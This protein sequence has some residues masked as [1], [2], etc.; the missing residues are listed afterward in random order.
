MH[1]TWM[2]MLCKQ[3]NQWE[4]VLLQYMNNALVCKVSY[5]GRRVGGCLGAVA[6][7]AIRARAPGVHFARLCNGSGVVGTQR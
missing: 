2:S 5:D 3:H 7:L 6:K 1:I 4:P